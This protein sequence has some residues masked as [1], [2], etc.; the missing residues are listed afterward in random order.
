MGGFAT[1]GVGVVVVVEDVVHD[2]DAPPTTGSV[3]AIV[4]ED[5]SV[6]RMVEETMRLLL[7]LL[8]LLLLPW[9]NKD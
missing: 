3:D 9:C 1:V 8:R 5:V 4:V 7:R 2:D 6:G